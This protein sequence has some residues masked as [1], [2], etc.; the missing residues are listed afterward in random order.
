MLDVQLLRNDLDGVAA[1]LSARGLQLDIAAFREV[2][3]ARKRVQMRT[4]ELQAVRN[5]A[6]KQIGELKRK[7]EDA[8]ALLAEMG[9]VGDELKQLEAELAEIQSRL[10]AFLLGIPNLPHL[11]VVIGGSASRRSSRSPRAITSTSAL[12]SG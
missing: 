3:E 10:E 11:D 4:Q 6:S 5:S 2:E 12:R 1:R 9:R 7:G 8:G